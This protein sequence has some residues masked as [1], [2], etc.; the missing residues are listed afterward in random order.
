M[1]QARFAKH[2]KFLKFSKS[3]QPMHN[4]DTTGNMKILNKF[5]DTDSIL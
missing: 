2:V 1:H 5:Y 4:T 3:K